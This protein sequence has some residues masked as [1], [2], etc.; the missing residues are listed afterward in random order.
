MKKLVF[1]MSILSIG[2]VVA[3]PGLPDSL[4]T[5]I[6]IENGEISLEAIQA[7][8]LRVF[9][10]PFGDKD[11]FG[12]GP[13][14]PSL[15]V[16][17]PGNRPGLLTPN[18]PFSRVNGLDSQ[19]CLECHSVRSQRTFPMEFTIGGTGTVGQNA[20]GGTT[21]FDLTDEQGLG[22]AD[23]NGR[24]IN[25]PFV[26]GSGGLTIVAKE[27]TVDLGQIKYQVK[28]GPV[29]VTR[30]LITR[31]GINFGTIS[32][33]HEGVVLVTNGSIDD[34]L[35]VKPFGRKGNNETVRVFDQGAMQFHHGMQP[36]EI[37]GT[38]IDAD[39]DGVSNEVTIG[40]MSAL[41]VFLNSFP[42]PFEGKMTPKTRK[43]KQV[44]KNVGCASC[45]T[46]VIHTRNSGLPI[47]FPEVHVN[48]LTNEFLRLDMIQVG[49]KS[50]KYNGIKVKMYSD[51][52]RHD[53][54]PALAE[55]TGSK[56]DPFFVTPRLWGIADSGPY[57][58]DGR[59][60][61]LYEAIMMHGGE[62]QPVRDNFVALPGHQ[63][64][65]L[66]AFLKKLRTPTVGRI[67]KFIKPLSK[68]KFE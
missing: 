47:A 31:H 2:S 65:Q 6:Q 30:D 44:F 22:F 35:V 16:G 26:F 61:T 34:D 19:S 45:H 63:K 53:M 42:P 68:I 49:F 8:G 57:M 1:L 43:G 13:L 37:V 3:D 15:P 23:T 41:S 55:L 25:P 46:P 32:K 29:G 11:G 39:N 10:T 66:V 7:S 38:G 28:T 24:F 60:L 14:D 40:E 64:R 54:G 48:P 58:H 51:L 56:L 12:D 21:F 20:F 59:A 5:Q 4:P 52:K 36:E 67:N 50:N 27:M 18:T 17:A 9:A 62:A 33:T